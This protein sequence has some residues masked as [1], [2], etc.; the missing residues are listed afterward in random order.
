V[1]EFSKAKGRKNL[2]EEMADVLEI[3]DALIKL[4]N[5][6]TSEIKKIQKKKAKK[7]G[8]FKDRILMLK[9]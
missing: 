3:V 6:K 8:A 1:D 5:L 7:R 4:N 9:K 2:S